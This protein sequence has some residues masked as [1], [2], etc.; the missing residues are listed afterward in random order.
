MAITISKISV[1]TPT[2]FAA[3]VQAGGDLAVDTTYYYRI[4]SFRWYNWTCI[5]SAISS[6]ISATTT[7]VNKQISLTWDAMANASGYI[8][9]RSTTSGLYPVVGA[10]STRRVGQSYGITPTAVLQNSFVDDGGALYA[11]D[12]TNR[13]FTVEIPTIDIS[14]DA[15][16]AITMEDVYDADVG[17]GWGVVEMLATG[18]LQALADATLKQ[19]AGYFVRGNFYIH[20]CQFQLSRLLYLFGIFLSEDTVTLTSI[21]YPQLLSTAQYIQP[22][23]NNDKTHHAYRSNRQ[24]LRGDSGL[25]L[26]DL[27]SRNVKIGPEARVYGAVMASNG[28]KGGTFTRCLLGLEVSGGMTLWGA[29]YDECI[30]ES[31]RLYTQGI[32]DGRVVSGTLG[33]RWLSSKKIDGLYVGPG[34]T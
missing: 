5:Y 28:V 13:D 16:D 30:F 2:T 10:N 20:D 6:E 21:S 8:I 23:M 22:I 19:T 14:S 4:A 29:I 24:S 7:V 3:A 31:A 9:Q 12:G 1:A 11:W 34:A 17:G 18:G 25:S 32:S 27:V 15:D 33:I 26:T